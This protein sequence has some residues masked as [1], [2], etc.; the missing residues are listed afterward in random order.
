MDVFV[1]GTLTEPRRVETVLDSYVFVG[2]VVLTGLHPVDGTY[3][4]LAPGGETAGRLFRTTELDALDDYEG[5]GDGLYVRATVPGPDGEVALYVGDP[6]A[7]DV[8]ERVEWPGDGDFAA[9]VRR[10][11]DASDASVRPLDS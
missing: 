9:R 11:L 10:Y 5:V 3:P 6:D 1:Y 7:L 4:T 2:P 8:A